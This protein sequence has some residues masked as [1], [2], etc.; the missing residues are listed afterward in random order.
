M[1]CNQCGDTVGAVTYWEQAIAVLREINDRQ[2]LASSLANVVMYTLNLEQAYEAVEL[3]RDIGWRSGE[4]YALGTLSQALFALG[5][6][7]EALTIRTQ[8]LEIAQAIEHPQWMAS[9]HIFLGRQYI[10]LLA[11]A[12]AQEQLEQGLALAR[13]VGSTF[14]VWLGSG[15]LASVYILQDQLEAAESLLAELPQEWIPTIF[16][17]RLAQV[18]LA[19]ARQ[20]ATRMLQLLDDP[21][22]MLPA[23]EKAIGVVSF[24][25]G[26][27]LT[28]QGQ[29]LMLQ[30]RLDEAEEA[31][32]RA[33]NLYMTHGIAQSLWKIHLALGKLYLAA[34]RPEQAEE[35]FTA[36][37]A[38][39]DELAATLTDEDLR[40]NFR[41]RANAMIPPAQPLTPRQAAKEEFGGLTQRERQVAAV[42]ARGLSNQEIAGE[43]VVS[44]KTVEAHV[45]RI[46]SKLGFSSRAQ[47]AAWTVEKGLASAPQD[48][49]SLS[50][51]S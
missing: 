27:A 50:A 32:H 48:L 38:Q 28:L 16:W 44:V 1:T 21:L 47:I 10:E 12:K 35:S 39:V 22:N 37:R 29:A 17:A 11:L 5:R 49:D 3:A 24:A 40:E 4:A 19:L 7:G 51:D 23:S 20:D 25:H 14:F 8:S 41:R 15:G 33:R 26:P 45:T 43:L 9:S 18:E 36:A 42:V 31:L 2:T 13:Q 6:Y 34:A 30:G 46:L